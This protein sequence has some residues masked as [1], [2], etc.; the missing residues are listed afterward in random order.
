VLRLDVPGLTEQVREA[1]AQVGA[2]PTT[3]RSAHA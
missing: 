3:E 2:V 1:I